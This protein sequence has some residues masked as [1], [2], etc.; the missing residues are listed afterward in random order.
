MFG[1]E[2]VTKGRIEDFS[3]ANHYWFDS[4]IKSFKKKLK[5]KNKINKKYL[6]IK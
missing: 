4:K 2:L 3:I 6:K 1:E 5:F